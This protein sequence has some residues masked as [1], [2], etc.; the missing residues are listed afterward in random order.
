MNTPLVSIILPTFNWKHEWLSQ[1]IDSV[2][3]QSYTN[4]ELIIINDASTNT[5]EET[6]EKYASK[7]PR[8]IYIKNEH[9]LKL[10]KTLNKGIEISQG[11]YIARIDDDDIRCDSDKLKKQVEFMESNLDYWL[12]GTWIIIIDENWKETDRVLNRW[13]DMNIR[14]YISWSNQFAHSSILIRRE[15]VE[16]IWWYRDI[17][18]TKY[19]EDYDLWLRIWTASKF[20]NLQEYFIKYRIREWSISWR[21]RFKQLSNAFR[22]YLLYS[23]EYPNRISWITKHLITIFLPKKIVSIFVHFYHKLNNN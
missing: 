12:I 5:I 17:A 19:T 20:H 21:N 6:I 22:V 16:S 2:L 10:T 13:G 3:L 18:I 11:E 15:I 7:D 9:N 8:I 4:F 23:K 1:A 14:N